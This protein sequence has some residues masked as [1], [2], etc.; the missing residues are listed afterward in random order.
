VSYFAGEVE[1]SLDRIER[2]LEVAEALEL[3]EVLSDALNTKSL[4]MIGLGRPQESAAL[5]RHALEIAVEHDKPAAALRAFNNL[6]DGHTAIDRYEEADRFVEDGLALARRVGN[7]YWVS[8]LLGHCYAK[9][10]LGR[11]DDL[12]A[13]I[14]EIPLDEFARARLGFNQGY[15]A[16]GT[17]ID[18]HRGDL[19]AAADRLGRFVEL[20]TSA[21]VQEVTEY[22][23]GAARYHLATGDPK[24]ALRFAELGLQGR[25][26]LSL[27]HLSVKESLVAALEAALEL[28]EA[29]KL[30]E[31]LVLIRSDAVARRTRFH[32]AHVA[33]VEARSGGRPDD[34]VDR[35]FTS[36]VDTF[37]D[38]GFP[39][40]KAVVLL[41]HGEWLDRNG[42]GPE[43]GPRVAE[44]RSIFEG[45]Q[46]K[47]WVDRAERVGKTSAATS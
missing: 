26:A 15:V 23:C 9:F 22:S 43:A 47:P 42:R 33:R 1:R 38:I 36:S 7:R 18:V 34:E 5:L 20:G 19:D 31:L 30:E 3:P 44:A 45:L 29:D 12:L 2:A 4:I 35:L 11:W 16:F 46:A 14:G 13:A 24:E 25:E 37:R 41:E 21:D 39:F 17:A 10:A 32:R 6:A 28:D 27:T 8:S 40:W